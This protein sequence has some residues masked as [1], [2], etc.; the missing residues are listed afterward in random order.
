ML[1][2]V[3]LHFSASR[4]VRE[5]PRTFLRHLTRPR[6]GGRSNRARGPVS[7]DRERAGRLTRAGYG[8]LIPRSVATAAGGGVT[9]PP[10][11]PTPEDPKSVTDHE[12]SA[13]W[14][15]PEPPW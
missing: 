3:S 13:Q 10:G 5:A 4:Q 8:Q 1:S 15:S 6:G 9:V 14:A 11:H 2:L 12:L 7:T